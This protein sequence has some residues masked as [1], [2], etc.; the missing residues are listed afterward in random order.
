MDDPVT[1]TRRTPRRTQVERRAATRVALMD[2][3]R[4]LF[5]ENGFAATGTPEIVASAGVTRGALYHQFADK[6]ELFHAVATRE[7]EAINSAIESATSN[8][9]GPREALRL[10]AIAY[11][12]AAS[13]HGRS[14]ILLIQ[15]PAV[16]GLDAATTLIHG[17]GGAELRHGLIALHP[18]MATSDVDALTNILSAA[19]DRAALAIANGAPRR[20]YERMVMTLL[21][22]DAPPD[23]SDRDQE[24]AAADSN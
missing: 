4:A 7:A 24:R 23:T 17:A 6:K 15:A 14:E 12:D 19:F 20:P 16:M 13:T 9:R 10:G 8:A 5:I 1:L 2:A 3:A 11:F 18:T 21:D 22:S